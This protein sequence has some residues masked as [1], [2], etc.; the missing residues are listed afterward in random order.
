[1]NT[2]P[3][4]LKQ[5]FP[6][7]SDAP[8]N[9]PLTPPRQPGL[10]YDSAKALVE[11]LVDNH[12][13]RHIFFNDKMFHN[14]AS[15]HLL[16][17]YA[18]GA[19]RE[20]LKI[21]YQTHVVYQRPSFESPGPIDAGNWK[22]HLADERYYQAYV[23]FF[24]DLLVKKG[25]ASVIKEYVLSKDA[26]VVPGKDKDTAPHMLA[27]YLGGFL[28]PLIHTGYGAEFGLLGMWAE[29]L[30]EAAVQ[31]AAPP[32]L[33]PPSLFEFSAATSPSLLSRV[34]SLAVSSASASQAKATSPHALA[35]LARITTD[36]SFSPS[37]LGLPVPDNEDET[38]LARV[39]RL[40]G[41]KLLEL[42][43]EWTVEP[44]QDDLVK[45]FEEVVWMNV[46]VYAV[47]GYAGR[48]QGKDE[49]KEFNGDFF[50]MHLI[51]SSLFIPSLSVHLSAEESV[52]LLRTYFLTCLALYV[53]RGRPP[54]PIA[55]FYKATTA[56]P[57]PPGPRPT[58]SGNTYK[59]G[60]VDAHDLGLNDEAWA[61]A[62]KIITPNPWLPILQTTLVHPNEHLCK[63]QRALA[64]F[65]A[66]F[67]LAAPGSFSF[68]GGS[69]GLNG[70]DVLDGT[71]FIRA[72]GLTANRLGWMREGE[73]ERGWDNNGFFEK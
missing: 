44:T 73:D 52:L 60:A 68:L 51:T 5:L 58:P 10:T 30:A 67:G 2:P 21:A 43:N 53:A 4:L 7:P 49:K 1:M 71:L 36:D 34:A 61:P 22:A 55:E 3:E 47:G 65:S 17:I 8:K 62:T 6:T 19:D 38:A 33:F 15:H 23:T 37:A 16:A 31:K 48:N 66:S 69:G 72:A 14:H 32:A 40:R 13:K 64:H 45:K 29:G 70:A 41:D 56:A 57:E 12:R 26:N 18:M 63:I 20:L 39:A 50:L 28:H 54:L 42:F 27:R 24:T 11:C 46:L 35:I 25:A 59:E 9:F